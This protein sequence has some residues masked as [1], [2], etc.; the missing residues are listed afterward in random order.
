MKYILIIGDG[1]ADNPV[2]ALDNKTPLQHAAIPV[3][4]A[5]AAK[6]EVGS[7]V[8]CPAGLP[9]G[10]DTAIL[11]IFGA[12]PNLC[13]T[14]RSPLEAA[15]TG[16]QLQPGDVSYR[17][18][19]VALEDSDLPFAEKKILSHSGGSIEGDQSIQL[20]T[21]LFQDPTFA[22]AAKEAGVAYVLM[23]H[24]TAH[25]AKV[26]YSQMATQMDKLGYENVFIG[27]VEGEPE[28]TSCEAVIAAV[29]EA[30][31]TKVVLRPLMVV[32]GDHANNDMAGDDADSWLSQF[33]AAGCFDSVDTQIAGLG[34]IADVQQI[35]IDHTKAAID[36][37]NG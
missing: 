31:Y 25:V 33:K 17:C 1:M 20:I 29:K 4:D 36:S 34:E 24:G 35:Y 32:A 13:Y 7:V 19:M 10:S 9:A 26:T 22:A 27:T 3:M 23:G 6:G 11:S 30:G 28:D 8:N 21:D 14:G 18:N 12:D 16:I 15:A 2:P 37:L 5:L